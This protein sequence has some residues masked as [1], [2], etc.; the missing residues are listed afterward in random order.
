[1]DRDLGLKGWPTPV[2]KYGDSL[3]RDLGGWRSKLA[4]MGIGVSVYSL[5]L[6]SY[7]FAQAGRGVSGP[8]LYNGQ[9][10]TY[11]SGGHTLQLTYDLGHLASFLKDGQFA[12]MIAGTTDNY[13]SRDG[14][15]GVRVKT[16]SW[17]QPVLGG[18]VEL[19]VGIIGNQREFMGT[20]VGGDLAGGTLGPQAAIS[21]ES[22]LSYNQYAAPTFSARISWAKY[23]YTKT[24]VQRSISP[25]GSAAES[26]LNPSG[27]SFGVPHAKALYI[28]EIG[29]QVDPAPGR[30]SFW[31][32]V[33]GLYNT[34][35]YKDYN[36][37]GAHANYFVNAAVDMQ[38]TQP[39][40]A[41]PG[42]G[43]YVGATYTT[44]ESDVNLIDRYEEV[45]AYVRGPIASRPDDMLSVVAAFNGY[46]KAAR[47]ANTTP[48]F[49]PYSNTQSYT[50]SYKFRIV[51][52]LYIQ[53]GLNVIV[54]PVYN[55]SIPTAVEGLLNLA[56]FF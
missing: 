51:P 27:V 54:H 20:A 28:H 35:L 41:H 22:G 8:Q 14:I 29:Y 56:T 2:P 52:G 1:M 26:D 18:K 24:A 40:A 44:A 36:D 50:A 21:V 30:K 47:L 11:Q 25:S 9:K 19:Q 53:P 6:V 45:R 15:N 39:S 12:V 46:S 48:G 31:V 32:R 38:V 49:T 55:R 4:D 43:L 23:L 33:D 37:G 5:N 42:R 3:L 13:Q 17:F 10:F 7:D 16:L 34:S